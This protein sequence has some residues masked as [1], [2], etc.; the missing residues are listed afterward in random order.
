MDFS[1]LS[2]VRQNSKL[3]FA[4]GLPNLN[5]PEAF[6]R[7]NGLSRHGI[8]VS[9]H[10]LSRLAD[11]RQISVRLSESR[12][13]VLIPGSSS[14]LGVRPSMNNPSRMRSFGQQIRSI[15][16]NMN[17]FR[18]NLSKYPTHNL[19]FF[20]TQPNSAAGFFKH[21]RRIS[22]SCKAISCA[23]SGDQAQNILIE[24]EHH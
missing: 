11:P 8:L 13:G 19:A 18:L 15:P 23:S 7:K 17:E 16:L 1:E 10:S 5:L 24:N 4:K 21:I 9:L 12:P 6:S 20:F 2:D 3:L 14:T 22:D